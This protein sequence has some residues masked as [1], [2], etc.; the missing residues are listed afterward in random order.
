[1]DEEITVQRKRVVCRGIQKSIGLPIP[2]KPHQVTRTWA[3]QS[4]SICKSTAEKKWLWA[5]GLNRLIQCMSSPWEMRQS[6]SVISLAPA[7]LYFQG[8]HRSTTMRCRVVLA[9]EPPS[10][11]LTWCCSFTPTTFSPLRWTSLPGGVSGFPPF[12]HLFYSGL[13]GSRYLLEKKTSE[14]NLSVGSL[15]ALGWSSCLALSNQRACVGPYCFTGR[16]R[17]IGTSFSVGVHGAL[18]LICIFLVW[19]S[20]S[21][22]SSLRAR[23][24]WLLSKPLSPAK[25][26]VSYPSF[27]SS[28]GTNFDP[29]DF[30]HLRRRTNLL[31]C[32]ITVFGLNVLIILLV[33]I[34][35]VQLR[36]MICWL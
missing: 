29:T 8:R 6:W 3:I 14:R 15:H 33:S 23:P 4:I 7:V 16:P 19:D 17:P 35:F 36:I 30:C 2:L 32:L 12:G 18:S 10:L 1:M 5:S 24:G 21:T 9:L 34:Q 22:G 13:A 31:I 28:P 26:P 25:L 20:R 27:L 11:P